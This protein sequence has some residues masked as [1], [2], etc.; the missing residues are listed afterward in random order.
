MKR[1]ALSL[2]SAVALAGAPLAHADDAWLADFRKADLNDSGGLSK[3]ELDKSKAASLK[4]VRDNFKVIDK[5]G[6][7][8][9]TLDEYQRFQAAGGKVAKPAGARPADQ[10]S[11]DCG[12][13]AEVDRYKIE[14][15]GSLVGAIA[16]GVAGGL[17]GSQVGGGTGKTI[18][19]VGGA[20]GGAYAGHQVEKKLKTKKMVKVT[21]KFDDGRQQDFDFEAEKSPFAKGARV[22]LRDG[23]LSAYTG[24]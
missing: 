4:P 21:V 18:A 19:T 11:P 7:G 16:G 12:Y 24:Q 10:C 13:V 15:E 17:L 6:D 22:Q 9:V 14:G 8:Q 3:V 23:Q 1:I 20:A 2:V 5:D